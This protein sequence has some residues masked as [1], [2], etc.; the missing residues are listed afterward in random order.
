MLARCANSEETNN[1]RYQRVRESIFIRPSLN[2]WTR[3]T[4][5]AFPPG[6]VELVLDAL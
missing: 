6:T 1:L 5:E 2:V 4:A 3:T